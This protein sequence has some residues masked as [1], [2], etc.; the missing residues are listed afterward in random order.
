ML[1]ALIVLFGVLSPQHS[2]FSVVNFRGIGEDTSEIVLLAA[3]MT[4][5]MIAAGID[6]S[7]GSVVVFSAV[8]TGEL[9][10]NISGTAAQAINL[11]FPHLALG[12]VL[13]VIGG[14]ASGAAWGWLN[15]HVSVRWHVPPFIV[16]LGTL[17]M[18]LGVAQFI[19]GGLYVPNVPPEFQ[20]E[21]GI[22]VVW[23]VPWLVIVAA[24]IVAVLWVVPAPNAFWVAHLRHRIEPGGSPAG[25][26]KCGATSTCAVHADGFAVGS[27]RS[28]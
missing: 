5:I 22:G 6:L 27:C 17:G 13:G 28:P 21:F 1:V 15:G 23:G 20:E 3:G 18:A 7:C 2:F 19:T 9:V 24:V 12:I 14:V 26:H 8:I 4:F 16:T 10:A 11:Q 25:R